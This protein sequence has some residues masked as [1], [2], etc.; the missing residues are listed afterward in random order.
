MKLVNTSSGA[1]TS[2]TSSDQGESAIN[3][4]KRVI[5]KIPVITEPQTEDACQFET[6]KL[7]VDAMKS[8]GINAEWC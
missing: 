8:L 5:R 3:A 2:V 7:L 4:P 1:A 6:T